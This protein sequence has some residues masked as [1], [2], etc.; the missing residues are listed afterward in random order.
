MEFVQVAVAVARTG[1][2]EDIAAR[3]FTESSEDALRQAVAEELPALGGWRLP[4][5][6]T[7]RQDRLVASTEFVQGSQPRYGAAA[8][9]L[10]GA[11]GIFF[12]TGWKSI[13]IARFTAEEID[14]IWVAAH[15]L[16]ERLG[17]HGDSYV[18]VLASGGER[19]WPLHPL[20]MGPWPILDPT[21][22]VTAANVEFGPFSETRHAELAGRLGRELQRAAGQRAPEPA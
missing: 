10:W 19:V 2:A 17:G 13:D 20:A 3:L 15:R 4:A 11:V 12:V 7:W 9:A 8:V 18:S 21:V 5:Q 16:V 6:V 22:S 1:T 14:P